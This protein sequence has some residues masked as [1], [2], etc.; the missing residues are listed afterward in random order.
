MYT[1]ENTRIKVTVTDEIWKRYLEEGQSH[2]Q[3][4]GDESAESIARGRLLSDA[5]KKLGNESEVKLLTEET[6][7]KSIDYDEV[8]LLAKTILIS[9]YLSENTKYNGA[10]ELRYF[11]NHRL[12]AGMQLEVSEALAYAEGILSPPDNEQIMQ[13]YTEFYFSHLQKESLGVEKNRFL[14]R[15]KLKQSG[16]PEKAEKV[17]KKACSQIEYGMKLELRYRTAHAK[18]DGWSIEVIGDMPETIGF[19]RYQ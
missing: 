19:C 15:I 11:G 13:E 2:Y 8:F 12:S 5:M 9:E 3:R 17:L 1:T 16:D 4:F 7:H 10:T 18:K 14:R 6:G